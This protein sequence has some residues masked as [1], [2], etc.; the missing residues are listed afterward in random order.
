MIL[1]PMKHK[2]SP[3]PDIARLDRIAQ[4]LRL[5]VLELMAFVAAQFG[6]DVRKDIAA[7]CA[8][9]KLL[10]AAYAVHIARPA[11]PL[12][13]E[14]P[15][16]A[17]RGLRYAGSHRRVRHFMRGVKV[18]SL[19]GLR[20]LL[21]NMGAAIARMVKRLGRARVRRRLVAVAFVAEACRCAVHV[22]TCE[23]AD[24]S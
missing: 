7:A 8:D 11:D 5:W 6:F 15:W 22:R 1:P 20:L 4:S 10:V 14:R 21:E 2:T 23:G 3:L 16:G 18:R 9:A 19:K 12:P 17:R 13:S 24:T